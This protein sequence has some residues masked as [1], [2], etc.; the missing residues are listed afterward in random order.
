MGLLFTW[1][2]HLLRHSAADGHTKPKHVGDLMSTINR[3]QHP[4]AL[5]GLL[6]PRSTL[7]LTSELD[8]S[9]WSILH[10]GQDTVPIVSEAGL[11]PG[12]DWTCA[13]NLTPTG[14]QS[15][16]LPARNESLYRLRYFIHRCTGN[17]LSSKYEEVWER[18]LSSHIANLHSK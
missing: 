5:V 11:A 3:L 7:Y 13:A 12:P 2:D 9:G 4:W 14:I 10:P 1:C 16:D 6:S 15:T 17:G 8:G 18:K